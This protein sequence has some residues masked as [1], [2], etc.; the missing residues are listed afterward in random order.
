MRTPRPLLAALALC[1]LALGAC[2]QSTKN[3]VKDF[4]GPQRSVAKAVED[5][6]SAGKD[7]DA[8]KI[9]GQLLAGS[10]IRTIERASKRTCADALD[11]RLDDVD[12]FA[13]DVDKV[14][15]QGTTA[16]VRVTSDAGKSDR[17]D[18]LR[19]VREGRNWKIASLG[20][21]PASG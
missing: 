9:C 15:V 10:L 3:T 6:E 20:G 12:A 8:N 16:T 5:L 19:L 2:T 17:A 14:T 1:A 4:Q 11:K 21:A 7:R 13:L 18:T